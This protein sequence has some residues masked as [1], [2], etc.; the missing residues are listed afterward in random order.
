M[1]K[2]WRSVALAA[3]MLAACTGGGIADPASSSIPAT[4]DDLSQP[5][6]VV[7]S[8]PGRPMSDCLDCLTR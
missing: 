7:A 6:M 2:R 4:V 3:V 8:V 1:V 5:N